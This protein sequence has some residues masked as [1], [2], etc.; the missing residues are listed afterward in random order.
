MC[1]CVHERERGGERERERER[2]LS[3]TAVSSA[4][5]ASGCES[6]TVNFWQFKQLEASLISRYTVRAYREQIKRF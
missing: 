3:T 1:V 4:A 2:D 6:H 5:V